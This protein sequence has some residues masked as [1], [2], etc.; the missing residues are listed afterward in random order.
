[1][2]LACAFFSLTS[3][4]LMPYEANKQEYCTVK[5]ISM[6]ASESVIMAEEDTPRDC[7]NKCVLNEKCKNW[8]WKAAQDFG[9]FGF[10]RPATCF[11]V[12][13]SSAPTISV[14]VNAVS[15]A[16]ICRD[17]AGNSKDCMMIGAEIT[18]SNVM[19]DEDGDLGNT[20]PLPDN[21][22][23][24]RRYTDS[25]K[26][27]QILCNLVGDCILY[28]WCEESLECRT[29]NSGGVAYFDLGKMSG[30]KTAGSIVC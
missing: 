1:M 20:F 24:S 21:Y 22:H 9:F 19:E 18:D 6:V 12:L 13:S 7:W 17:Q 28:T 10:S 23:Y 14:D 11:F 25:A 29:K 2:K 4:Q 26:D 30:S 3:A 27:C 16:M 15:G 5:G 8:T